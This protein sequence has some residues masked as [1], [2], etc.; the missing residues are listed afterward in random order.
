MVAISPWEESLGKYLTRLVCGGARVCAHVC[1][2][3]IGAGS[4]VDNKTQAT[5]TWEQACL[6]GFAQ[7]VALRSRQQ[8]AR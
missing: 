6:E 8:L 1:V 2:W 5:G 7:K 4:S 3:F